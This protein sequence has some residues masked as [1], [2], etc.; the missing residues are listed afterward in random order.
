MA[1]H[2]AQRAPATVRLR[3]SATALIERHAGTLGR[4]LRG[5]PGILG[6]GVVSAGAGMIYAPAGVI[7]AG[8]FLLAIDRGI[9]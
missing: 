6:A 4:V 3:N 5:A 1:A 9:E 8:L 7:I 2:S